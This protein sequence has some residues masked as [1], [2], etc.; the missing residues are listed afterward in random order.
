MRVQPFR[1][2]GAL[3]VPRERERGGL[4]LVR[5]VPLDGKPLVDAL[6]LYDEV[7]LGAVAE[8]KVVGTSGDEGGGLGEVPGRH[9]AVR[10]RRSQH[11]VF[12]DGALGRH[13]RA[14]RPHER[15]RPEG[16]PERVVVGGR[17]E[18]REG[19]REGERARARHARTTGARARAWLVVSVARVPRRVT[20]ASNVDERGRWLD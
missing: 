10:A 8:V 17:E 13:D 11:R 18:E 16:C 20:N 1:A 6:A 14:V 7:Q 9:R 4:V 12:T 2:A 5:E 3:P 19:E 15:R